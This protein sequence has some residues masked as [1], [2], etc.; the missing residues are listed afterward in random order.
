MTINTLK[1]LAI[2]EKRVTSDLD[3]AGY[4]H[5]GAQIHTVSS[6]KDAE[7]FLESQEINII[8]INYDFKVVDS[9]AICEHFK[10][11]Y[12]IP[13][14]FTSVQNVP[15]KIL[16]KEFG[17]DLYIEQPIPRQYFIEKLRDLLDERVRDTERV[18]HQGSVEFKL[19]GT[20]FCCPIQDISKSGILFSTEQDIEPGT[21][22]D[23]IFPIP[24]YKKAIH[25]AGEV[26]RKIV[27]D[28]QKEQESGIG[29]RFIEFKGDSQKRLEKYILKSQTKSPELVYYL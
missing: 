20:D 9:V 15:K 26:V 13:I 10:K 11:K 4:K 24:G 12:D 23:M 16:K 18:H 19:D 6:F 17:P 25:V 1:I 29:V 22:I 2:D 3:R 14:V 8:V 7:A 28:H 27:P 21:T 5:I